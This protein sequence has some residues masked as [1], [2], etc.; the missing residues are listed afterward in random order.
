MMTTNLGVPFA[1]RRIQ[2]TVVNSHQCPIAGS[3]RVDAR[4]S[5]Q[6]VLVLCSSKRDSTVNFLSAKL[7]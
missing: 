7:N 2:A 1:G 5:P 4:H 6:G 3:T